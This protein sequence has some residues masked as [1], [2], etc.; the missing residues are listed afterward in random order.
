[1]MNFENLAV[2]L[3]TKA[4]YDQVMHLLMSG[5]MTPEVMAALTCSSPSQGQ[6]K[7]DTN[8]IPVQITDNGKLAILSVA[9]PMIS[10]SSPLSQYFGIVS[11]QDIAERLYQ[12]GDEQSVKTVMINYNTPGGAAVGMGGAANT[13]RTFN[14]NVKPVIG[15]TD[16]QAASSGY[17]LFAASGRA[18]IGA[19]AEVGSVGAIT[20]HSEF[21]KARKDAG[22]TDTVVRSNEFKCLINPI[23]PLTPEAEAILQ[24]GVNR[25]QALFVA[26]ISD[27]RSIPEATVTKT[28][29]NGKMYSA[30]DAIKLKMVDGITSF[31]TLVAKLS[32]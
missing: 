6:Q 8:P 17:W 22:I 26:G 9:G 2:W 25:W 19:D 31:E 13:I 20:F 4:G 18:Y 15:Y 7:Q 27:L 5:L 30:N 32:K 11:Y 1:M 16:R 24:A 12:L 3:G 14:D 21:S 10:D 28:I 29:A 23:E